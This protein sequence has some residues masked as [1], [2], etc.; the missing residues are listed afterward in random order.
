MLEVS[1]GV[2]GQE[3]MLFAKE[4]YDMYMNYTLFKGWETDVLHED[5]SDL[6]GKQ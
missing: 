5:D 2:G 6:G 4:L 3:A 1:T